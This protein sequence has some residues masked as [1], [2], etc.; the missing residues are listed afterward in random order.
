MAKFKDL[1]EQ[2]FGKLLVVEDAGSV[3]GHHKFLCKCDCGELTTVAG[4]SLTS[5]L[6][7][8]CGCL[9]STIKDLSGKR[10]GKLLVLSFKN[11]D[12][13][14]TWWNCRCDCGN[15]NSKLTG[16]LT[17]R[18]RKG[19]KS[20][21][22]LSP[23]NKRNDYRI[24]G[25]TTYL[26]MKNNY[27]CIIDTEDLEKIKIYNWNYN[28][29][30]YVIATKR[31]T[32][33]AIHRLIMDFPKEIDHINGN[34][35]DNRK[36][37]L[38]IV[39]RQQNIFNSIKRKNNRSGFKG[40]S[41]DKESGKYKVVITISGKRHDFGRYKTPEEAGEVYKKASLKLHKEYSVFNR[42]LIT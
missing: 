26:K 5:R 32:Y 16:E 15:L 36:C 19:T 24:E 30:Y 22:C 23:G 9:K 27:E 10:F 3:R 37:N 4:S 12:S 34:K 35:F 13:S 8:S 38:R 40:I 1:S 2:R 21:G 18:N 7:K 42:K 31:K 6:T 14:G 20:C 41:F 17:R 29:T 25:D 39:T 33:I 11:R 28:N